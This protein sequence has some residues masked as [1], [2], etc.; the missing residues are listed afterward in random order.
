MR[1]FIC[2]LFI[3]IFILSFVLWCSAYTK[4]AA[5]E[6]L[7]LSSSGDIDA[8]IEAFADKRAVFS[9]FTRHSELARA[10]DALNAARIY[11]QIGDTEAYEIKLNEFRAS[12]IRLKRMHFLSIGSRICNV[13]IYDV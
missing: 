7:M 5:D 12:I 4:D 11:L 8:L 2:S 6:L 9:L 1:S 3:L 10:E 13:H